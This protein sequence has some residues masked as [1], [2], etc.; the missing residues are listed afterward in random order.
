[1]KNEITQRPKLRAKH[2]MKQSTKQCQFR[3]KLVEQ[4]DWNLNHSSWYRPVFTYKS[5][6]W[7]SNVNLFCSLLLVVQLPTRIDIQYNVWYHYQPVVQLPTHMLTSICAALRFQTLVLQSEG[8][9]GSQEYKP[10]LRWCSNST[11][12]FH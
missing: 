3:N 12:F 9:Q 7:Y 10:K 11:Q 6:D 2:Q 1:M 8:T 4:N 5:N